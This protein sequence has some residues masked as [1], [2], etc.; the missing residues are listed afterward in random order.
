MGLIEVWTLV[1]VVLH[2]CDVSAFGEFPVIAWPW[3]WSCFCLFIWE[4][5]IVA[6]L[7]AVYKLLDS[8]ARKSLLQLNVNKLRDAGFEHAANQIQKEMER[9]QK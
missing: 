3:H 7:L 8:R 4:W 1:A 2:C 5:L 9:S 6:V